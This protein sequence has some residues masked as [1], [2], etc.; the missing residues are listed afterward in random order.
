MMH[1]KVRYSPYIERTLISSADFLASS[2]FC[3]F[4]V[5]CYLSATVF[6]L[7]YIFCAS[8]LLLIIN[9]LSGLLGRLRL[10]GTRRVSAVVYAHCR[11]QVIKCSSTFYFAKMLPPSTFHPRLGKMYYLRRVVPL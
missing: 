3:Q 9:F 4:L 6:N 8:A 1:T 2:P 7:L 10:P 11:R 5:A